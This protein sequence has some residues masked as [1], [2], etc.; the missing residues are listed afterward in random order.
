MFVK[1]SKLTDRADLKLDKSRST[2][3]GFLP[4]D[5]FSFGRLLQMVDPI[6]RK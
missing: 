1:F 2:R 6:F 5:A 4:S 3:C